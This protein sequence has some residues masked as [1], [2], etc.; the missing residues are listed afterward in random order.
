MLYRLSYRP[1]PRLE[2]AGVAA[3]QNGRRNLS[4]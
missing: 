3:S 1:T 2:A 4:A